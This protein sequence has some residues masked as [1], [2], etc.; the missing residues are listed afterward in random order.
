MITFKIVN[1]DLVFDGQNDLAMIEGRDEEVQTIERILTTN[2]GEWFL[3][4]EHGLDYWA[5]LG[6]GRDKESI[7]LAI[8]EA[9]MQEERV[10]RVEE[11]DVK[12]DE[13]RHMKV[14]CKVKMKLGDTLEISEVI[15][16]G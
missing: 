10:E 7:K 4:M 8:I 9:I 1:N 14:Y 6:K 13:S 12:I 16:I 11:I 5:I 2:K 15:G 3:N